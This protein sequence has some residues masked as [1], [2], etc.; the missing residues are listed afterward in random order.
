M[1]D[2]QT[3]ELEEVR[4]RLDRV[5]SGVERIWDD[6]VALYQGRAWIALGY[7]S[8]DALCDTELGGAR[9]ALPRQ[10]RQEVVCDLRESGMSTRAIASAVGVTDMTV[11]RDLESSATNVAVVALA[12][13]TGLDGRTRTATPTRPAQPAQP[14]EPWDP[15]EGLSQDDLAAMSQGL[16]L[17]PLTEV[18]NQ[19]DELSRDAERQHLPQVVDQDGVLVPPFDRQRQQLQAT[20]DRF[21]LSADHINAYLR[22]TL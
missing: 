11:R 12:T 21:Q 4:V 17:A 8:W 19:L 3:L 20:A 2:V 22:S 6:M 14:P 13:I 1:S 7:S 9:I 16:V 15:T 5:K 10:Q 18:I